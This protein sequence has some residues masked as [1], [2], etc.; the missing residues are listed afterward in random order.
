MDVAVWKLPALQQFVAD[1]TQHARAALD[2]L[3][4]VLSKRPCI[5]LYKASV[6]RMT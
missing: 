2:A 4:G 1:R 5:F 3:L 6:A